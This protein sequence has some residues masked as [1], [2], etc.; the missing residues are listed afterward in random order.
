MLIK[1]NIASLVFHE[2]LKLNPTIKEVHLN[3][4]YIDILNGE[5]EMADRRL[6]QAIVLDPDYILAYEN[7]VLSSQ[8]QNKTIQMKFYLKKILE[9]APRHKAKQILKNL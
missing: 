8:K 6:K 7:L 4:G 1:K 5:Y 2:A 9:I 3:L